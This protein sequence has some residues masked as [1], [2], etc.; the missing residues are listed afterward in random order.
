MIS[1]NNWMHLE[2]TLKVI[3][4]VP[5]SSKQQNFKD[6]DC[7]N[8]DNVKKKNIPG[9][10]GLIRYL[11]F[12]K[13]RIRFAIKIAMSLEYRDYYRLLTIIICMI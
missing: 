2:M 10:K 5:N 8:G 6:S 7:Y 12:S 11:W 13:I 1:N 4:A 3:V 9:K